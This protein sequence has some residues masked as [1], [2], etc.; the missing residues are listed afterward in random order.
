MDS[1]SKVR[2]TY[3]LSW[4]QMHSSLKETIHTSGSQ[5]HWPWFSNKFNLLSICEELA[6]C[7][8]STFALAVNGWCSLVSW[9]SGREWHESVINFAKLANTS[10]ESESEIEVAQ[11][12]PTLCDPTDCSLSSSSVHGIFQASVLEWIAI[13]FSRRSSRARNRTWVSRIAGRCFT[14]WATRLI[15]W[16]GLT[17]YNRGSREISLSTV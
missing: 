2:S 12:C 4:K 17:P 13:S 5:V 14:V 7:K 11:S 6:I 1:V 16:M 9:F 15:P 10:I 3:L 8:V